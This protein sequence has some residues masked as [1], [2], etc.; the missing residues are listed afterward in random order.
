MR[1]CL[2][3]AAALGGVL[4]AAAAQAAPQSERDSPEPDQERPG[5][6]TGAQPRAVEDYER[7][8]ART[9]LLRGADSDLLLPDAAKRMTETGPRAALVTVPGCGHAPALNVPDQ[10]G[11]V[12]KFLAS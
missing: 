10:I 1:L 6:R 8:G 7:I 3:I 5:S 9:F 4:L 2:I 12:M 11:N